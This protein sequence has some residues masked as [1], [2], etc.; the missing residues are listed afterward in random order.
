MTNLR[1]HRRLDLKGTVHLCPQMKPRQ[2]KYRMLQISQTSLMNK[3]H[4]KLLLI[5]ERCFSQKRK[6]P[7]SKNQRLQSLNLKR[8]KRRLPQNQTNC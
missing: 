3:L 6:H 5:W 1:L 4:R 2:T 8:N 7:R